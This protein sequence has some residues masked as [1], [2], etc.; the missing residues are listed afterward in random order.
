MVRRG[1]GALHYT[2]GLHVSQRTRPLIAATFRSLRHRDFR[3]YF[4]GQVVSLHGTW[5]QNVAQAWLVYRLTE[6]SFMLGLVAF[7]SLIPVLVFSLFGGVLADRRD[8]RRLLLAAHALGMVQAIVLATLTLAGWVAPWHVVV[9]ALILGLVHAF[10]MPARHSLVAE[11]V[12]RADLSNAVALNSGGFNIARFLGPSLAGLLVAQVGE[13]PVFAINA[14]SFAAILGA[15]LALRNRTTL[16]EHPRGGALSYIRAAV[17]HAMGEPHIRAGLLL[18]GA[19]SLVAAATTVLMPVFAKEVFGGGSES[20]G[21]LLGAMGLGSMFGALHLARRRESAGMDRAVGAAGMVA[22]VAL[23]VLSTVGHLYL[24]LPVLAV[25]GFCHTTLV[26]STNALIQLLAPD[27]LRGRLMSLFSTVFIGLMPFGSLGAGSAAEHLG[28]PLTLSA[29][30]LLSL[31]G[32][33]WFLAR[34]PRFRDPVQE[35]EPGDAG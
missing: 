12:P 26:A 1:G 11:L 13:G 25:V 33:A 23:L 5:M 21:Y 10:E 18:V 29:F 7:C 32:G 3:L 4:L 30:A 35:A 20:L 6:S 28:A 19:M 16:R 15:L 24:A 17:G 14:L 34:V 2:A 22:G 27:E 8:R 31:A 9:L